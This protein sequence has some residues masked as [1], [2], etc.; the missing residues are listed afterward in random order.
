TAGGDRNDRKPYYRRIDKTGPR[1]DTR[2]YRKS[3]NND[4]YN[5]PYSDRG[6]NTQKMIETA[7]TTA[8]NADIMTTAK[9]TTDRNI[10]KIETDNSTTETTTDTHM[11]TSAL[12]TE[13]A[14][15]D[16][17]TTDAIQGTAEKTKQ[18]QRNSMT[19]LVLTDELRFRL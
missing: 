18:C 1:N 19:F 7:A 10:K 8:I 14:P 3:N 2:G 13:I 12:K 17:K 9:I 16:L 6:R 5:K 4:K 11:T 15:I